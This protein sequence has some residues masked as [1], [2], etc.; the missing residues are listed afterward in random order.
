[1]TKKCEIEDCMEEVQNWMVYCPRHY[2]EKMQQQQS[3]QN[4]PQQVKE[5]QPIQPKPPVTPAQ[6][7]KVEVEQTP[8]PQLEERER[9]IV[10]QTCLKSAIELMK[11]FDNESKEFEQMISEV[12]TLTVYFYNVVVKNNEEMGDKK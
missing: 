6:V 7:K 10:K 4:V 8:L 1:M 5:P 9:L 11:T 12:E 2:A 3:S